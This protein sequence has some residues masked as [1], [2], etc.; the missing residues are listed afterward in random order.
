MALA[1]TTVAGDI[2]LAGDLAGN[3]NGASPA[4]TN[5]SV[6]PGQYIVAG[7][8]VDSKGRLTAAADST[9]AQVM[10]IVPNA[11][12]TAKGAVQIT[13]NTGL[14]ISGGN[15]SATV[16]S[17]TVTG[18]VKV[19]A[20]LTVQGDGTL[21]VNTSVAATPT[22]P[23]NIIVG[24]GLTV[25]T[26]NVTLKPATTTTLGGVIVGTGLAVATDG[27]LSASLATPATPGIV[28]VGAGLAVAGGIVSLDTPLA[29][30]TSYGIVK[31]GNTANITITTGNIDVGSNVALRNV[32]NVFTQ[33]QRVPVNVLQAAPTVTPDFQLANTFT[34]TLNQTITL[35]NPA[36]NAA[37]SYV[38]IIKQDA[39]GSRA[40]SFDTSYVFTS[41]TT[42]NQLANGV[43]IIRVV[44]DVTTNYCSIAFGFA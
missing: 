10:S 9:A 23:G 24:N 22:V 34:L 39:S 12:T 25:T 4:L 21:A 14:T 20:G 43:S 8:T 30:N 15:L 26:G 33:N 36:N 41:G 31:S 42:I 1:T 29:T 6:T 19:G 44:S 40:L 5:T 35:A 27:T 3:N 37:G 16:A 32:A 28:K 13:A 7:V 17:P 11:S 18:S 38:I 2:Q